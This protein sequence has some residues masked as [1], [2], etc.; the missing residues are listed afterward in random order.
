MVKDK[1]LL[2][3]NLVVTC[4]KDNFK[5]LHNKTCI[6]HLQERSIFAN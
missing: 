2:F 6:K 4:G 3:N 1:M 5:N